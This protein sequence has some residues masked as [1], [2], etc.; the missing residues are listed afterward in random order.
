MDALIC[1]MSYFQEMSLYQDVFHF[2]QDLK[3]LD[4]HPREFGA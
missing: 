2:T 4:G 3:T 1:E